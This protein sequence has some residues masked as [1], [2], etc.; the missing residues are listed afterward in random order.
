M[1]PSPELNSHV[2]STPFGTTTLKPML[3]IIQVSRASP[4]YNSAQIEPAAERAS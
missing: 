3:A 4:P 1:P 2:A